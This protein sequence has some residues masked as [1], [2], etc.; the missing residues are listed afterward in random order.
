[1]QIDRYDVDQS[2]GYDTLLVE[3]HYPHPNYGNIIQSDFALAKLYGRSDKPLVAL[4]IDTETPVDD[5]YLTVMGWGVTVEGVSSTQSDVLREVDVQYMSNAECDA[6]SGSYN[7]D[8]VTYDGYIEGNMMCAWSENKDA[9]QG[10]SGGPLIKKGSDGETDVQVGVV[11]WG[12]GC[13]MATFP[14]V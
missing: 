6:S 12:L 11:S 10:D 2:E 9:C 4:N 14:G 7:G 1:M 8:F 5:E 13:A 3:E